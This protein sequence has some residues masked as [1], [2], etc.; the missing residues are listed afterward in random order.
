MYLSKILCYVSV[1]LLAIKYSEIFFVQK[2]AVIAVVNVT[3][4]GF[5]GSLKYTGCNMNYHHQMSPTPAW[6]K[7]KSGHLC[8]FSSTHSTDE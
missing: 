6:Q 8:R 2:N 3:L 5:H 7:V 1:S 4:P